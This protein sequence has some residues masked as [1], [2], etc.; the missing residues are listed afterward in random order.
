MNE[1]A[2][3]RRYQERL[4]ERIISRISEIR[5]ISLEQ[6]M[7]IDYDSKL[8]KEIHLGTF[9]IQYVDYKILAE[10]ICS[11]D[12]IKEAVMDRFPF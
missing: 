10:Q 12:E 2:L 8:A 11:L 3:E 5:N 1:D 6:A 9:G 4:E 7:C